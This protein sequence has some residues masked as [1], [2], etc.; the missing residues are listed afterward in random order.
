VS[1]FPNTWQQ[2][3]LREISDLITKGTTPTS[4]G[5]KFE[6]R[7]IRF[8][9]IENIRER[10]IDRDSIQQFISI[11]CHETLLR[12]QLQP[13]DILFSIAGTIGKTA[14]V[15]K[16]DVP[17]NTNQAVSII[18]V[19]NQILE[20]RFLRHQLDSVAAIELKD[21]A[22][23]GAMNNVSL[24]D[25]GNQ[26]IRIPP[27]NEQKRIAAKLDALLARVDACRVHLDRVPL[28]FKHFRQSVLASAM[29]GQLTEDWREMHGMLWETSQK[30]IENLGEIVTGSTPS[31]KTSGNFGGETPFFKPSDLDYGY[32]VVNALEYLSKQGQE[33][34]RLLPERTVMVTCIG[35]TIGKTG[36][37]RRQSCPIWELLVNCRQVRS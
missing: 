14:L 31:K 16:E 23:G 8:V 11:E 30:Q 27:L 7:G 10:Q 3:P 24:A 33:K 2:I 35:A 18:R 17:A 20:P 9:K 32:E 29:S 1:Q 37:S 26:P 25:I 6:T 19:N 34:A 36:F 5:F 4:I 12:S 28:L 22:R 21:R 15:K 13:D